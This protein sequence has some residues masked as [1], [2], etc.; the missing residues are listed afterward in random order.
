[1]DG[2]RTVKRIH[3]VKLDMIILGD[4]PM[5]VIGKVKVPGMIGFLGYDVALI[6]DRDGWVNKAWTVEEAGD[7]VT[8]TNKRLARKTRAEMSP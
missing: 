6:R 7:D 2:T 8:V 5:D 3:R 4:D 1:M